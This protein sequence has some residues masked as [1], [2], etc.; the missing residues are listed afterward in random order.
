MSV[1][2]SL[3][4]TEF[5]E[6][7]SHSP[8]TLP[9]YASQFLADIERRFGPRDRSFTLVGIDIDRSQGKPPHLWFQIPASR[10]T[11]PRGAPDTSLSG[12][13]QMHLQTRS[14]P[15]GSLPTSV[16]H[17][18][19]PWNEKVDERPANWLEEGLAS[20]YQ[21]SCVPEAEHHEGLY[22]AAEHLVKP[23]VD[24]LPNAVKRI[25][26]ERRL[27]ISEI[28]PDILR[29]YCP[30]FSEEMLRELCQPFPGTIGEARL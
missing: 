16:F 1:V 12:W 25:R 19:D 10:R 4:T 9:E 30:G 11:M 7:G 8:M 26:L 20:W 2:D 13:D 24:N 17:L 29:D 23:L 18:L 5:W 15:G 14:G 3:F 28:T 22:A 6:D 21:N 27:R